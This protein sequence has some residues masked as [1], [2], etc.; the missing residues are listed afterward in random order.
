MQNINFDD[1]FAYR[2]L[3]QDTIIDEILIIRKLKYYLYDNNF[4][5]EEI[6]NY[7]Y[8]FYVTFKYA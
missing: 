3:C 4:P 6:D 5:L 8:Q 2:F 7:I 1:L